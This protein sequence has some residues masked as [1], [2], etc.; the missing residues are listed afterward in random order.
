MSGDLR[1]GAR[2]WGGRLPLA[3]AGELTG[4]QQALAAQLHAFA[5]PWAERAG[6]AGT[7][8]EGHL[9][10]PW[11]A[12]VHR[13]GP[14]AG[15]NQWILADQQGSTL[16]PRVREVVI[17]TVA[18]AWQSEYEIYSHVAAAR[19]TGLP[20][21][22]IAALRA[23]E[24]HADLSVGERAAHA[25]TNDL[26]RSHSVADKTYQVALEHLG[27]DGVLDL[28]QLIGIYLATAAQLNAFRVPAPESEPRS[29]AS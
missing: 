5:V 12:Q 29:S 15:F 8:E 26:V 14:A 20:D 21:A 7:T 23:D 25:F 28:V 11:N 18:I 17:L 2:Q 6:F 9:I 10:G 24:P 22:A 19:T 27:Q 4:Q 1:S 16:S 13:P 3:E